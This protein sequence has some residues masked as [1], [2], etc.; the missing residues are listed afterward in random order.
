MT[1]WEAKAR[2]WIPFTAKLPFFLFSRSSEAVSPH[3]LTTIEPQIAEKNIKD[4][5]VNY[6]VFYNPICDIIP[7]NESLIVQEKYYI[8]Q[9]FRK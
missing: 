3:I 2:R 1:L 6:F 4:T 9:T 8:E 7:S 5:T